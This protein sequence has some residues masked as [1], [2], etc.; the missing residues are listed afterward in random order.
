M[1]VCPPPV[2]S[3]E[4]W[5][6]RSAACRGILA[7]AAFGGVHPLVFATEEAQASLRFFNNALFLS[8]LA[9]IA[10]AIWWFRRRF[11]VG[12]GFGSGAKV[13]PVAVLG[14]RERIAV[15]EFEDRRI[16]VGVTAHQITLLCDLGE[17]SGAVSRQAT[18]SPI[19]SA[20]VDRANRAADAN[21]TQFRLD[22]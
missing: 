19:D 7:T 6:L 12:G 8:V 20:S 16:L 22:A 11:Q 17:T 4:R 2:F 15:V 14:A 1:I 10:A 5:A 3:T 9:M 13:L 21:Q 18:G